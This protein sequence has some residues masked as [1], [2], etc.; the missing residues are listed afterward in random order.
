M[1]KTATHS[2]FLATLFC[3][4]LNT[5]FLYG[6]NVI[7]ANQGYVVQE[8]YLTTIPYEE[9]KGKII[10][11][12]VIN[13]KKRKFILDTGAVTVISEKLHNELNANSLGQMKIVD[14]SGLE[15][16]LN[17]VSM[18]EIK[19]NE[20]SFKD[21]PAIVSKD[22]K[23]FFECFE[24]NGFI[25]SNLLRNSV[26]QFNSNEKAMILSDN[27]K[28]LNLKK[29]YS[30]E[31]ELTGIQSNPFIWIKL[32]KGKSFVNEKILFDTGADGLYTMSTSAYKHIVSEKIEVFETLAESKGS[33]SVGL[34]GEADEAINYAV[35][36]STLEL[37]NLKLNNVTTKTTNGSTSLMG[38]EILN[39]G[40]VTLDYK[41][42][43]FYMEPFNDHSEID[44]NE[45]LWAIHPVVKDEKVIVGIV[46]DKTLEGKINV[47]DEILKF[48]QMD[49]QNMD[50]C[51][52]VTS[53]NKTD[54]TKALI[55]LK[56]IN[57]GETKTI[58][59]HR[60]K[61]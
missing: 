41:N 19:L 61:K 50:F 47:G 24:I 4:L 39:Y 48:D 15:S 54:K 57:T 14:Q 46:W 43:R 23:I 1:N 31:M 49:Y 30:N 12:V 59:V 5:S 22:S 7:N 33:F 21:I 18:P 2:F 27:P 26:V 16:Q 45:N 29:K 36:I 6:Q 11:E 60:L 13:S 53:N 3:L 58:E 17:V 9:V 25:G 28:S 56:D 10:V 38:S 37:N 51:E 42:K 55:T 32:K 40:K 44:L 20:V 34:L 8:K 52:I 35:T